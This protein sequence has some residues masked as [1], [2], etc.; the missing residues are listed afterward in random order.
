VKSDVTGKDF[1]IKIEDKDKNTPQQTLSNY[2]LSKTSTQWKEVSIPITD[3]APPVISTAAKCVTFVFENALPPVSGTVYI[4]DIRFTTASDYTGGTVTVVDDMDVYYS[5]SGWL[6]MGRDE[7]TGITSTSLSSVTGYEDEALELS[8]SFNRGTVDTGDWA[9]M[10]RNWGMNLAGFSG[11]KFEYKGTGA[12]NNIEFK[13]DDGNKVVF[14][15]KIF[16]VTNTNGVWKT[17]TVPFK[18]FDLFEAGDEDDE[19]IELNSITGLYFALSK[20]EGS[21]GTV[22]IKNLEGIYEGDYETT[23]QGKL[24]SSLSVADNPFTPDGDGIAERAGFSFVLSQDSNIEFIV[25]DLAGRKVYGSKAQ[26]LSSGT[27][28][29]I[30]WNGKDDSGSTVKNGLYFYKII[31]ENGTSDDSVTHVIGVYR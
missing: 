29:T 15:R 1:R 8:Y 16:D 14:W 9:V 10:Y 27:T 25:F 7:S 18:D 19:T 17:V 11:I 2:Y 23:R 28:H 31:A 4:D 5:Q 13:I 21:T 24:I 12:S 20:S 22:Y 30:Y 6:P 26:A 3:F